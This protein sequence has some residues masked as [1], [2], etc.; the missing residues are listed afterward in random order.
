[1]TKRR[2]A[3]NA[4]QNLRKQPMNKLYYISQG[5]SI[6]AHLQ[7]IESA[8][9]AGVRL[10]QLRLKDLT[11]TEYLLAAIVCK[12]MCE[13]KGATFIVNDN[14]KVAIE[15][16]ADGVH[17]GQNDMEVAE[18]KRLMG[19]QFIVGGTANTFEQVQKMIAAEV[20][21]LG[22][23]PFR[24]TTTK[25]DLSPVLGLGGYLKLIDKCRSKKIR[26]NIYAIGGIEEKDIRGIKKTGVYGV[27][28]SGLIT[29]AENKRT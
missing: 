29:N 8:L 15:S 16:K 25:K 5:K 24:F 21:Y 2:D 6:E 20:D 11:E 12:E 19:N 7:N 4:S 1:M 23:G 13:S 27:A 18:V 3:S 9:E 10:I 14:P 28:V 17:V 22:V 26:K